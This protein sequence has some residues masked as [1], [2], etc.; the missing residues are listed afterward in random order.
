M[1]ILSE[2]F[3]S[4]LHNVSIAVYGMSSQVQWLLQLHCA[5]KVAKCTVLDSFE[6]YTYI[7]GYKIGR[8]LVFKP[9]CHVCFFCFWVVGFFKIPC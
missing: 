1:A 4:Y 9:V 6:R 2:T 8:S 5:D 3:L 7:F